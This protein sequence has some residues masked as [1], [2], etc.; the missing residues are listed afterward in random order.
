M[1]AQDTVFSQKTERIF[2]EKRSGLVMGILNVTPDSFYDG[3]QFNSEEKW[4]EH[5][6]EMI[7]EGADIIDIGAY[8]TRPGASD[9]S[10]EEEENRLIPAIRSVRKAFPAI[11]ISA[12]TFRAD[13]ARKAVEAGADIINDVGGGTLDENMFRTVAEM[14]VPYV[15]MHIQGTPQNMQKA[16]HYEDVVQEVYDYFEARINALNALGFSKIILDPG[17]GFGKTVGHNLSLLRNL[18]RF[19]EFGAPLLAGL[20]RKS[21]VN[22]VLNISS[23]DSLNGTTVLNTLA[24][25]KGADILRVHDVKEAVEA[26]RLLSAFSSI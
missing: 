20:S 2:D 8:S 1:S 7:D 13:I 11:M 23:K 14:Q 15:L 16:P 9:I 6:H 17:F 12:D 22:K 19:K 21:I 24:I 5:A 25:Q 18:D 10:A 26:T 3:G 4:L